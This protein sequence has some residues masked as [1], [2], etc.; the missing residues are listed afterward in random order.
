MSDIDKMKLLN[1][2]RQAIAVEQTKTATLFAKAIG[3]KGP[4]D[5]TTVIEKDDAKE[6]WKWV[7]QHT[8][9]LLDSFPKEN[10]KK[11]RQL[12]DVTQ[13]T[14]VGDILI[15]FKQILRNQRA[16]LISRKRYDWNVEARRQSYTLQYRI[17]YENPNATVTVPAQT[18]STP[19]M[20]DTTA[21]NTKTPDTKTTDTTAPNTEVSNTTLAQKRKMSPTPTD[22]QQ[23]ETKKTKVLHP[24]QNPSTSPNVAVSDT[25]SPN[26][27]PLSTQPP[28]SPISPT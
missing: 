12:G 6:S 3:F 20:S 21:P 11:L 1:R 18:S 25:K 19:Q 5:S 8:I 27:S 2:L 7:K 4:H 14:D 13:D 23:Q 24:V 16:R 26:V 9:L 15:V 28:N 22:D 10:T 17:I